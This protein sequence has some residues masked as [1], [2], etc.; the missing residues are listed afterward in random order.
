M[1]LRI[2]TWI[3]T[4]AL[5]MSLLSFAP[6]MAQEEKK[7][8][9]PG[10][11]L[12]PVREEQLV[13][14][15]DSFDGKGWSG[16]FIPQSEDTIYFIAG[17]DNAISAKKTL[18]YFWPISGKYMAGWK[19]LSEDVE[20]TLEVLQ[21]GKVIEKLEKMDNTLYYPE[22]YYGEKTLFYKGE[23]ARQQ[24]QKYQEAMDKY[25]KELQKFY[26]ARQQY[27]EKLDEF[28]KKVKEKREA[29]VEGPLD[30]E[31]PKEPQPPQSPDFYVTKPSKDYI[32]N[33][34][35]GRYSIRLRAKDGTIVE[36]SEKDIFLFT[37]RRKGGAG[38]EIIPGNRWTKREEC[39]KPE[40][41]MYASGRNF[42]Y[43]R[44][45][46]QN[47][48]N[49]LYYKKLQDPQ[50]EGRKE[51]WIWVH[52]EPIK[53]VFLLFSNP[54]KVLNKVEKKPYIVQQVSGPELGYDILEYTKEE[55]PYKNPTF[56]GYELTLTEDLPQI[57][58]TVAL[59]KKGGGGI[60]SGSERE[61]RLVKK[62]NTDFLYYLSLFPLVVWGIV[63]VSRFRK[64][65]R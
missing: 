3:C 4:V 34:P 20:G 2:F 31:V 8:P 39:N 26:E 46:H 56:E 22:G 15:W 54:E 25:Y 5:S 14:R 32:I 10:A 18:V 7:E 50:N 27:R 23:K 53:D 1:R 29:G 58:Y 60:I 51:N 61:I 64:V 9:S 37:A 36:G 59:E 45:Y 63:F 17:K 33:L 11:S 16:G 57:G 38:Y 52:T 6:V 19:T 42:L 62:E 41:I 21:D 13:Y 35:P 49:E 30:I 28:F 24:Y 48:Y 43:F 47:E 12:V 44:P 40:N 65:S 55:F